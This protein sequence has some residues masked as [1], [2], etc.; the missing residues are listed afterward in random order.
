[1]EYTITCESQL[2]RLQQNLVDNNIRP[3]DV[4]LIDHLLSRRVELRGFYKELSAQLDTQQIFFVLE[5]VIDVAINWNPVEMKQARRDKKELETVNEQ[6]AELSEQLAAL[7]DKRSELKTNT[8]FTCDSIVRLTDL[9]QIAANGNSL[10]SSYLKDDIT[11]MGN[12]FEY[13]RYWPSIADTVRTIGNDAE[14]LNVY[15][16]F[17]LTEVA[18]ESK[19]SSNRDFL[20]ALL[21]A[22]EEDQSDPAKNISSSFGLTD[23]AIAAVA[24]CALR[25]DDDVVTEDNVKTMRHSRKKNA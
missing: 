5:S 19:R 2:R 13:Y 3:R 24:T 10:F 25:L 15:S 6:I 9:I 8:D 7:L 23:A 1:M 4:E 16:R 20:R 21:V 17:T 12:Q 22:F 14:D 11:R 18:T